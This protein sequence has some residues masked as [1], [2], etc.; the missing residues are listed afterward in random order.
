MYSRLA[1]VAFAITLY[2]AALLI[3]GAVAARATDDVVRGPLDG[4][5]FAVVSY[6]KSRPAETD[7]DTLVFA[8][9][10]LHS[11]DRR[12]QGFA[13]APY[14][15]SQQGDTTTFSA[16]LTS[17]TEGTIGWQGTVK[18]EI[19]DGTFLW[20]REDG[21]QGAYVFRGKKERGGN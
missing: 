2:S 12:E 18:G 21:E 14:M 17:A 8:E 11:V 20:Q 10:K 15:A 5:S 13:P 3:C 19:I 6:Q 4:A 9:G 16:T 1:A 7:A